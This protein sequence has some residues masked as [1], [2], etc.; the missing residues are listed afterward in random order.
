MSDVGTEFVW[1]FGVV[2]DRADPLE[3]GR[4]RVRCYGYHTEDLEK[5]P[6]TDL[7]WAQPI[8]DITSA[9]I[10]GVGRS[11]TGLLEGTWVVGFFADG[12]QAQRPMI[13]GSLAGWP[14]Q[15]FPETPRGFF[16]PT[17][18]NPKRIGDADT[19]LL[20]RE[21]GETLGRPMKF[22]NIKK[23]LEGRKAGMTI[24]QLAS[25]ENL[26]IGK[27]HKVLLKNKIGELNV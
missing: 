14:T 4:V 27:V 19:P 10:G 24:R 7:P 23:I 1:W 20:A 15:A 25:E 2:E 17:G 18:T 26:S 3:L 5:I 8:Q 16:D 21:E 13:M 22:A 6:T 9:A 12:S 11:A